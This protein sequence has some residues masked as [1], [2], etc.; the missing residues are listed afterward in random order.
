MILEQSI[1]VNQNMTEMNLVHDVSAM[2]R[3]SS[4][5]N[6]VSA[7]TLAN[8]NQDFTQSQVLLEASESIIVGGNSR[9]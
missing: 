6:D 2:N 4:L 8:A 5:A 7:A 1:D 9:N 3:I